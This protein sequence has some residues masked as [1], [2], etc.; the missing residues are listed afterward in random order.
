MRLFF[1]IIFFLTSMNNVQAQVTFIKQVGKIVYGDFDSSMHSKEKE[2]IA[3][4]MN[5][6]ILKKYS[7]KKLPLVYLIVNYDHD[8]TEYELSYDNFYGNSIDNE[9]YERKGNYYQ[10]GIRIKIYSTRINTEEVLKLLDYGVSYIS[11]LKS[12][13][14]QALKKDYYDR[15]ATLSLNKQK[16]REILTQ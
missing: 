13:R 11:E 16:I 3:K 6:C 4:K 5:E 10:P 7:N 14:T 1:F 9:T 15:P 8:T 2:Q 12:I